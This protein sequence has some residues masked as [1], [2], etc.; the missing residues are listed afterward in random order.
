MYTELMAGIDADGC[1][2][3]AAAPVQTP[4]RRTVGSPA[5]SAVLGALLLAVMILSGT[6]CQ[7]LSALA[8]TAP[9]NDKPQYNGLT[10]QSVAVMVYVDRGV[11]LDY[12]DLQLDLANT[13]QT[14]L[15]ANKAPE[16]K[17]TTYPVEPRS[18][19]RYQKDHPE[20]DVSDVRDIAPRFNVSRLIY[21]E[22]G[23]F[24]TRSDIATELYRGTINASIK[25]LAVAGG[26]ATVAY[27]EG[28]VTETYPPK[29]PPQGVPNSTDMEIYQ[30][31]VDNFALDVTERFATHPSA[32]DD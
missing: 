18:I 28:N 8:S 2:A 9:E 22:V 30:G 15:E 12:P 21:I 5:R 20:L 16:L 4:R 24:S 29:A 32:E 23:D 3:C 13:I 1:R 19:V 27:N 31:I 6:G 11:L 26:K 17:G 7:A 25:V 14:K 10:G